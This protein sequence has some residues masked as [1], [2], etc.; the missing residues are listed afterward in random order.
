MRPGYRQTRDERQTPDPIAVLYAI[1]AFNEIDILSQH[2]FET[3]RRHI[4]SSLLC[5]GHG[6]I[7]GAAHGVTVI[8][9]A[10]FRNPLPALESRRGFGPRTTQGGTTHQEPAMPGWKIVCGIQ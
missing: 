10:E 4:Q 2:F 7:F 5:Q 9:A 8:G 3:H 1:E 6:H